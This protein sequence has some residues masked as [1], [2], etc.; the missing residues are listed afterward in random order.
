[1]CKIDLEDLIEYHKIEFDI[2]DGYYYDEGRNDALQYV[3]TNVFNERKK[4]QKEDNPLN[5][6]YKLICNSAYGRCVLKPIPTKDTFVNSNNIDKFIDKHYNRIHSYEELNGSSETFKKYKMKIEKGIANHCNNAHAGVEILAMSKRIMNEVMC[7][8]DDNNI[9][10][11][12]QDTDSMHIDTDQ[13]ERLDKLF[14]EKYNRDLRGKGM[15]QFHS[16][17]KS[18]ILKGDIHSVESIYLGKKCYICKLKG[19]EDGVYEYHIRMKGVSNISIL[20]KAKKECKEVFDIYASLYNGNAETFDLCCDGYK[21]NFDFN[22]NYT[23]STRGQFLRTLKFKK[24]IE[25]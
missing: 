21:I 10:I 12:Y 19:D 4:L 14:K 7:L 18:D 25:D 20:Y 6:V 16:D 3:I 11:Y 17:F 22:A 24:E 2:I 5:E 8:A 9:N 13:V 23:I 1:V 15:G